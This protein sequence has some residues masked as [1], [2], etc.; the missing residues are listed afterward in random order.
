VAFRSAFQPGE[1]VALEA[2]GASK[3][4][5]LPRQ[6]GTARLTN[7]GERPVWMEFGGASVTAAVPESLIVLPMA[8]FLIAL[9]PKATHVAVISPTKPGS[10]GPVPINITLGDGM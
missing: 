9:P 4:V 3:S 1:T 8:A 10:A 5:A 2:G 7:W 6:G